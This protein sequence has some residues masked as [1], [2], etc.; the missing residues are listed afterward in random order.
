[1]AIGARGVDGHE[2]KPDAGRIYIAYMKRTGKAGS[3]TAIDTTNAPALFAEK[4][5]N[6]GKVVVGMSVGDRSGD[7]VPDMI[8]G[9]PYHGSGSKGAVHLVH[10]TRSP[11]GDMKDAV[12]IASGEN[13]GPV[14]TVGDAFGR[15]VAVLGDIDGDGNDDLA[16]GAPGDR[17]GGT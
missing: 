16:V 4:N 17:D 5:D 7:G 2:D 6:I 8:V 12:T 9:S 3:L 11:M 13:G 10:L 1:V 15:A 14:L